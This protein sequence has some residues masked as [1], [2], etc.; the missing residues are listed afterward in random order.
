MSAGCIPQRIFWRFAAARGRLGRTAMKYPAY[1]V[2]LTEL[3]PQ[4][5]CGR[6]GVLTTRR[7]LQ[8]CGSL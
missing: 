3:S 5:M 4:Q 2:N 7:G 6:N 8:H 1:R